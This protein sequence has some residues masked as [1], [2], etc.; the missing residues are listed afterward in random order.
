MTLVISGMFCS[1]EHRTAN[2]SVSII[3]SITDV[4]VHHVLI[5]K[6]ET[7]PG[8]MLILQPGNHVNDIIYIWN[9]LL[10]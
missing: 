3:Q 6:L 8:P 10:R 2:I 7:M 9:I 4:Q 5:I 1:D